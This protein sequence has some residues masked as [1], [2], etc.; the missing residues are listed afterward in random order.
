MGPLMRTKPL[1][2]DRLNRQYWWFGWPQV[3]PPPRPPTLSRTDWTRL[4]PPP[5][6]NGH[7]LRGRRAPPFHPALCLAVRRCLVR[8]REGERVCAHCIAL[9]LVVAVGWPWLLT[10]LLAG[11]GC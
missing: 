7:A 6:L 1:G 4:V 9:F 8:E 5:V 2:R 11:R 3:D 10:R